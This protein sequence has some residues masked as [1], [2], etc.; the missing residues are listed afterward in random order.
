MK[1]DICDKDTVN[2]SNVKV[3]RSRDGA[4]P[5]YRLCKRYPIVEIPPNYRKSRRWDRMV[6]SDQRC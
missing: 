5:K 6:R 4:S 3:T 2:R 1:V